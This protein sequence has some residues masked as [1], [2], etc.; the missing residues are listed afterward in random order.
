MWKTI[1]AGTMALVVVG[2]T[3]VLAQ[4]RPGDLRGAPQDSERSA[5]RDAFLEARI[6]ALHAG[7]MLTPEQEKNWPAFEQAAREMAKLR[8]ERGQERGNERPR[9]PDPIERLQQRADELTRRASALKRLADAAAP[10]YRS[11]DEGQKRRFFALARP[12]GPHGYGLHGRQ[13]GW[14]DRDYGRGGD[15][16]GDRDGSRNP[17]GMGPGMGGREWGRNFDYHHGGRGMRPGAPDEDSYERGPRGM[18]PGMRGWRDRNEF[19]RGPAP[20]REL[21]RQEN[22][23]RL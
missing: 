17:H 20:R 14:G 19:Q 23:E 11:L 15:R 4:Q 21:P 12:I 2:S 13:G 1:V 6:A 16:G 7:L 9:A 22:E 3:L 18:E 8:Q 5:D 10:L